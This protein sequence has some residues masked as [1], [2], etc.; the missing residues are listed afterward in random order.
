MPRIGFWEKPSKTK[1]SS[2]SGSA[3]SNC[4]SHCIGTIATGGDL[5]LYIP[6]IKVA[7]MSPQDKPRISWPGQ[8]R[9][10][11]LIF[12]RFLCNLALMITRSKP[13]QLVCCKVIEKTNIPGNIAEEYSE[14]RDWLEV[15]GATCWVA[16]LQPLLQTDYTKKIPDSSDRPYAMGLMGLTKAIIDRTINRRAARR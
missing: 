12:F 13:V 2:N 15:I 9:F 11:S 1:A 14:G 8:H 5:F 6:A 10:P 4:L 16:T 3:F 7:V